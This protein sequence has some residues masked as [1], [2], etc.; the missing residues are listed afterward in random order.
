MKDGYVCLVCGKVIK[1]HGDLKRHLRVQHTE[2]DV[3]YHCPP[4]D[5]RLAN[6]DDGIHQICNSINVLT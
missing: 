2:Q 3:E 6:R 1:R 4:C 5:K